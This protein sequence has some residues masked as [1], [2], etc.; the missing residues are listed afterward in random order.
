MNPQAESKAKAVEP[1]NGEEFNRQY[2]LTPVAAAVAEESNKRK[3]RGESK[4]RNNNSSTRH[5]Q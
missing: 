4:R 1:S 5:Q 2:D 3:Q